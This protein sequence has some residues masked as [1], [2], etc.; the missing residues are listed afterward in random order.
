MLSL[1]LRCVELPTTFR[2]RKKDTDS[3]QR[4]KFAV[5]KIMDKKIIKIKII[6]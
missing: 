5:I 2:I 3:G 6:N 4:Y 1:R